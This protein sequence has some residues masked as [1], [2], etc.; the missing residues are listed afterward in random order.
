MNGTP[1]QN[2]RKEIDFLDEQ[3]LNVIAKRLDIVAKIG[4]YKKV[5]GIEFRDE[6]RWQEILSS[7]LKKGKEFRLSEEFIK[8]LYHLLHEYSLQVEQEDK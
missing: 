8:K 2:W 6:N 7:R 4:D 3:L 5:N 1:L